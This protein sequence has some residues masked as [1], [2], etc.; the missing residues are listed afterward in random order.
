MTAAQKRLRELRERQSK[1]RGRMAE[2]ARANE[3]SDEMRA[4]LDKIESGTP[5]LERQLRAAQI[6]VDDEEAEQRAA[7]TEARKPEG[8]AEDRERV[9]L[10][11]ENR[12]SGGYL[13]AAVEQRAA[14][15]VPKPNTTRRSA[16]PATD[17]RSTC[18][19][20]SQNRRPNS[21]R[22]R[23]WTPR[24]VR[25]DGSTGCSPARRRRASA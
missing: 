23:P 15:T 2:L 22:Q 10:R 16:L 9:E 8:D 3:L 7:G 5:D 13:A 17:S 18:S 1:E 21:A 12:S 14:W 19:R 24:R 25:A 4:E 11:G 6:A 20:R